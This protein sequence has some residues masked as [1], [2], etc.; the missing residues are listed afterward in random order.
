VSY[1]FCIILF[2]FSKLTLSFV[3]SKLFTLICITVILQLYAHCKRPCAP[4]VANECMYVRFFVVNQLMF[5]YEQ[6]KP[7]QRTNWTFLLL[8]QKGPRCMQAYF[9]A[10]SVVHSNEGC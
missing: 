10:E 7:I 5:V 9:I 3:I 8:S 1:N 2:Y 4:Y 6:L